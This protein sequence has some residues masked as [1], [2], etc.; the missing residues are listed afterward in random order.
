MCGTELN[1]ELNCGTCGH[2]CREGGRCRT[3]S[4]GRLG[5]YCSPPYDR[6]DACGVCGNICQPGEHCALRE[7]NGYGCVPN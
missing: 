4:V 1:S 6:N 3:N 5:C 7:V 2:I